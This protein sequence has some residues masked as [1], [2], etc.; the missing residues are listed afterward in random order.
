ME[1]TDRLIRIHAKTDSKGTLAWKT[2]VTSRRKLNLKRYSVQNRNSAIVFTIS[3]LTLNSADRNAGIGK[4]GSD[5]C[6]FNVL[7]AAS[8]QA[9]IN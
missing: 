1:R 3:P 8:R 5:L 2:N 7:H 6:M 4:T 9:I